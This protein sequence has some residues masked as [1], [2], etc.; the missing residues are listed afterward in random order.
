M[1]TDLVTGAKQSA[2]KYRCD[3]LPPQAIL[4][5]AD[6]LHQGAEKYGDWNWHRIS[7]GQHLNHALVHIFAM[8]AGDESDDHIGHAACRLLMALELRIVFPNGERFVTPLS[9][10]L[11]P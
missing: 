4:R 8:L 2:T 7:P 6:I 3:L 5:I 9:A 11:L 1:V 10:R